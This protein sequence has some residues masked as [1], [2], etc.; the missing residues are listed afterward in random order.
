M[1]AQIGR[2]P[3]SRSHLSDGVPTW[4]CRSSSPRAH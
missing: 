2:S 4:L 1:L 3:G